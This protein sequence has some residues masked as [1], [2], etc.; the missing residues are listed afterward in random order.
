MITDAPK[1]SFP[2]EFHTNKTKLLLLSEEEAAHDAGPYDLTESYAL[3]AIYLPCNVTA[4]SKQ[5]RSLDVPDEGE[6]NGKQLDMPFLLYVHGTDRGLVLID[7]GMADIGEFRF[8]FRSLCPY[9]Y[10]LGPST[11]NQFERGSTISPSEVFGHV[12]QYIRSRVDFD[13]E[14]TYRILA[15][16]SIGTHFHQAFMTYPFLKFEGPPRCGKTTANYTA[17]SISFHPIFTPDLS[18]ASFY[19]LREGLSATVIMDERDFSKRETS[20]FDEF[21]NNSFTRG[22]CVVRSDKD[23]NGNIVP[24]LFRVFGPF[25]FSG[26]QQ[27]PYMTETRTL[28]INM[29]RT[30]LAQYSGTTP[31]LDCDEVAQLRDQLYLL[32]L[33]VGQQVAKIYRELKP[34]SFG[35]DTRIWDIARPLITVARMVT[36]ESISDIVTFVKAQGREREDDATDR[37]EI[38]CIA[39][40]CEIVV[41]VISYAERELLK[42]G[43]TEVEHLGVR[44][45]DPITIERPFRTLAGKNTIASRAFDDRVGMCVLIEAMKQLKNEQLP[46]SI[47]VVFTTQ[48]EVGL[49]GSHVAASKIAPQMAIAVDVMPARDTPGFKEKEY[50]T[51]LGRGP[52]ITI[53]ESIP[54]TPIGLLTHPKVRRMLVETA[55]AEG[56]PYQREVSAAGTN[57]AAAIQLTGEGV[58]SG[59][60][61]IPTRYTHAYELL[62]TSDVVD[63]V[64][65]L[66]ASLRRAHNYL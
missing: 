44:I 39:K 29:R 31:L 55:E 4:L 45:G 40:A 17:G 59:A 50:I 16:W 7:S 36:P 37:E 42:P 12:L 62:D 20:R 22:G 64:R 28:I 54:D 53:M 41:G 18:D 8:K 32:R 56:I 10:G 61:T 3:H 13:D 34:E 52:T 23:S 47:Y 66:V 33:Q 21:L 63:S 5:A 35:L 24:T 43:Y 26:V 57:D 48:E 58:P 1:V 65:L 49:R 51:R 30:L 6:N 27:L 15:I 19:R 46:L 11:V 9:R 38:Q 14:V 25:S 60:I 2:K